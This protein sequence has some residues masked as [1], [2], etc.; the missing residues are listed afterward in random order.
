MKTFL[1]R[2]LPLLLCIVLG[3]ALSWVS[4]YSF[5]F[6]VWTFHSVPAARFCD[7]VGSFILFPARC[8]FN[9]VG[10]DQSTIFF[11]PTSFSGTNG[12]ILGILF[13]C[14]FRSVSKRREA[15]KVLEEEPVRPH[16]IEAKVG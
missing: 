6:A 16:R 8:V 1:N 14:V 13:Y 10:G 4:I 9:L 2:T 3:T 15:G 7:A 11:D 5:W 12:L